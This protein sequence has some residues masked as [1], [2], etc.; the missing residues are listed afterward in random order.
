MKLFSLW[1]PKCT[2]RIGTEGVHPTEIDRSIMIAMRRMTKV[3]KESIEKLPKR[4]RDALVDIRR[5]A[6][7]LGERQHGSAHGS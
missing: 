1:T 2:A 7:A 4:V 5:R 6:T 3:E